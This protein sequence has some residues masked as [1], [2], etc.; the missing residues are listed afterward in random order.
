MKKLIVLLALILGL[1][2]MPT[3]TEAKEVVVYREGK[4]IEYSIEDTSISGG[5]RDVY[6]TMAVSAAGETEYHKFRFWVE[7]NSWCWWNDS[8]PEHVYF[9]VEDNDFSGA[10]LNWLMFHGYASW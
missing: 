10:T 9:S 6:F 1:A 3:N 7:G 8:N 4:S 5:G 2:S